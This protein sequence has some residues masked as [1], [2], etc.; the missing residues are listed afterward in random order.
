MDS[1][2]YTY[3]NNYHELFSTPYDEILDPQM[4]TSKKSQPSNASLTVPNSPHKVHSQ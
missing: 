2:F 3:S 4:T 1:G